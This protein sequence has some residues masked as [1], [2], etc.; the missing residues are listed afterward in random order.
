MRAI[1]NCKLFRRHD[2]AN[3]LTAISARLGAAAAGPR[4][5]RRIAKILR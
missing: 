2:R 4:N 1:L 3:R 5:Q